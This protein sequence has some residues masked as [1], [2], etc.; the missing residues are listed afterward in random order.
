[1]PTVPVTAQKT[2]RMSDCTL[3]DSVCA[4]RAKGVWVMGVDLVREKRMRCRGSCVR[5]AFI[6]VFG[7][8]Y[9]VVVLCID[10]EGWSGR[11]RL[12]SMN[13]DIRCW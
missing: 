10:C 7:F 8:G 2:G 11:E 6:L 13:V 12:C 9:S 4:W 5:V 3:V 1:V